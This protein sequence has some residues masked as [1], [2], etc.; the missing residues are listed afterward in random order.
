MDKLVELLHEILDMLPWR[1]ES[2][3]LAAHDKADSVAEAVQAPQGRNQTAPGVVTGGAED[4]GNA[5]ANKSA[6]VTN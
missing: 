4:G 1:Q 5:D 2:D 3:K 6:E